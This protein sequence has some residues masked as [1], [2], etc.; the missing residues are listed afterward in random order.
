[1]KIGTVSESTGLSIHTIRYYEKQ[2]LIKKPEKDASG[3]R[4]YR[5][6]D[7][8]TLNWV[9]CM[10][11]SG[12]S[13]SKIKKYTQAFYDNNNALCIVSLEDHLKH[14][15]SQKADIEHYIEVTRDKVARL[16]KR[17]T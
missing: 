14:L 1:M 12:M 7:I 4:T 6:V 2:G 11:N 3:H 17:L 10:K 8:E 5:A 15:Q 13:L 16:K 9:S